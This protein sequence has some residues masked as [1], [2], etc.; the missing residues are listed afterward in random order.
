[1]FSKAKNAQIPLVMPIYV[2]NSLLN[3]LTQDLPNTYIKSQNIGG[4]TLSM[5]Q[6]IKHKKITAPLISP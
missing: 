6:I 3:S 2:L 1:M 4:Q 5:N